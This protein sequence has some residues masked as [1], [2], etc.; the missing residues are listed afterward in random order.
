[1]RPPTEATPRPPRETQPTPHPTTPPTAQAARES[2]MTENPYDILGVSRDASTDE[3]KRAYRK[4]ARENHPDLNPNDPA[5]ADRMNKINEAY[6]RII[7]PDKYVKADARKN[8]YGAPYSPQGDSWGGPGAGSTSAGGAAGYANPPGQPGYDWVEVNWEDIFGNTGAWGQTAAPVHPE[9]AAT[10]TAE[11]RQAISYINAGNP[12]AAIGILNNI[13]SAG[14]N[15]RWYYLSAIANNAAGNITQALEQIKRAQRMDPGNA[16]Y[17]RAERSLTRSGARSTSRKARRRD[18]P[19][20]SS[21]RARCAAA[22]A[23]DPPSANRSC[24]ASS[25]TIIIDRERELF[26]MA[27]I[28]IDLGTTNSCVA[29]VEGT[30]PEVIV[31]AEGERTTPSAVAF[32]KEGERLIGTI[33]LRQAAMNP[34]RTI[35]SVKRHMGTDWRADI[36][37]KAYSPQEI[38]SMILRKLRTDAETFLNQ[39]V[40]DAVITVPAY[41]NDMQRQA[42]K[43]AGRIAGLNVLRIIN[44]PTAAALAYGLDHGDPQMVMVYDL[45]GGTFDVSIIEIGDNVIE[46]LSTA[47]NNHLGGDDFDARLANHL[48]DAF[49]AKTGV[50]L[51][52]N[53]WPCSA[54]AKRLGEQKGALL[55]RVD[56]RE[57]PLPCARAP[58]PAAFEETIT[59]STFDRIT[60]DLVEA[61]EAR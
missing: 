5:A 49:K 1:M 36:D 45:G 40:T 46:V 7:N 44:E 20:D 43:D 56:R 35:T 34:D 42:T 53:R 17:V 24:S 27:V 29:V 61:T 2:I 59:R 60:R 9:P 11:V 25:Q 23:S 12:A 8:G 21:T 22:C 57:P 3:V 16:D 14:R 26:A 48:A 18:S 28:G 39:G 47:G 19:P 50:D 52:R 37:G 13:T 30:Q 15:A 10:D 4:K 54:F 33:A 51:G 55:H 32:S 58:R 6:D 31:N 38:S 41:F